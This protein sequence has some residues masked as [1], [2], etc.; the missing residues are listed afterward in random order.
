MND[1][2]Y[3]GITIDETHT[4]SLGLM[5]E[6]MYIPQPALNLSKVTVPG[7]SGALD[8]S[9]ITGEL[10][11]AERSGVEFTF[12]RLNDWEEWSA[13]YTKIAMLIHG[14]KVKVVL[15]NDPAY[16]YV[17]RLSV[18]GRKTDEAAGTIVLSG[19]AEPFKYDM[20]A[21]DEDW[22]W[23]TFSFETGVIRELADIE[24]TKDNQSVTITGGG[25]PQPI[26]ITVEKSKDLVLIY[27]TRSYSL[28][29]GTY[30]FPMI[31][32]GEDDRTLVF[33]GTGKISIHY[34]G[35]Y[36]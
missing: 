15:D 24:I 3:F 1:F 16:Y 5:M 12:S 6:S 11:Y 30:R 21:S 4:S 14:K 13:L 32:I 23:D 34:R 7:M 22:L 27:G 36:L 10:T 18:D 33:S 31:R 20:F 35:A 17:C 9:E 25:K 26:E 2:E 8:L 19:T 29:P 28:S